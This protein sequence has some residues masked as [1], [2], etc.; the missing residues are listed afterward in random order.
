[1]MTLSFGHLAAHRERSASL[2]V[3]H[4]PRLSAREAELRVLETAE[5]LHPGVLA[6]ALVAPLAAVLVA[7]AAPSSSAAPSAAPTAAPPA[8]SLAALAAPVAVAYLAAAHAVEVATPG[9]AHLR[10][11]GDVASPVGFG[12]PVGVDRLVAAEVVRT[13]AFPEAP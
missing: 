4:A 1:M 9:A 5:A 3:F 10:V 7:L 12:C 13:G 6:L 11:V 8:A 2:Q